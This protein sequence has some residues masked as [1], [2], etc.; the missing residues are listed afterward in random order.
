MSTYA[1]R[2]NM[3]IAGN[4]NEL[5][6]GTITVSF[7]LLPMFSTIYTWSDWSLLLFVHV[8]PSINSPFIL[9]TGY[10]MLPEDATDPYLE[11]T[12]LIIGRHYRT[13]NPHNQQSSSRSSTPPV[14]TILS[15]PSPPPSTSGLHSAPSTPPHAHVRPVTPPRRPASPV[16]HSSSAPNRQQ[17]ASTPPPRSLTPPPQRAL[18]PPPIHTI[19]ISN[20]SPFPSPR[21]QSPRDLPS[22]LGPLA[23]VSQMQASPMSSASGSP[24]SDMS[25]EVAV[26]TL[27]LLF[28]VFL[29]SF[30]R[31]TWTILPVWWG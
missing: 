27:Y 3:F 23:S 25:T 9:G 6:L 26:W 20:T 10:Y 17:R 13:P 4:P 19:H 1:K 24:T 18:T 5:G 28:Y 2:A 31:H 11:T 8:C 14:S 21:A 7:Y 22:G 29:I 15:P 12:P 16:H 30:N